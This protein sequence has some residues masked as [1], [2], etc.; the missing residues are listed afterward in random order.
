[1][2]DPKLSREE[3]EFFYGKL[4]TGHANAEL[5]GDT[6]PYTSLNGHMY[7]MLTKGNEVAIKLPEEDRKKFL[8]KY[9]TK[10][11][12]QYGIVQKE[13]VVVPDSLLKKT[14][15][16]KPYFDISYNYV[17]SLK[18]KPTAKSKKKL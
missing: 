5:K 1:M 16:L 15:E 18:P 12:E 7:S 11:V 4:V 17:G 14:E 10:L 13:F 2:A 3:K 9:K 8:A 6:I